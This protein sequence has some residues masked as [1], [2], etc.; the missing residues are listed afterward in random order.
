V[1]DEMPHTRDLFDLCEAVAIARRDGSLLREAQLF[2]TILRLYRSPE[3]L[4]RLTGAT[5]KRD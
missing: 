2:Q 5:L 3:T 4:M 1:L